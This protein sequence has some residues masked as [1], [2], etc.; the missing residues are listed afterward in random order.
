MNANEKH[1]KIW[2]NMYTLPIGENIS[3]TLEN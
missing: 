2:L 3:T 1:I